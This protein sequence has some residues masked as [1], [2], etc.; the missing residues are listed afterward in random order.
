MAPAL[1]AA[2]S[3]LRKTMLYLFAV[4]ATATM[5][6]YYRLLQYESLAQSARA[7]S[8]QQQDRQ[9]G[10]PRSASLRPSR[11]PTSAHRRRGRRRG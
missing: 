4:A 11:T 10:A 8:V 9:A 3:N 1:A 6:G 5:A 7:Q 2:P